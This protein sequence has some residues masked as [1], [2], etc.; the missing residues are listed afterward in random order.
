MLYCIVLIEEYELVIITK[1]PYADWTPAGPEMAKAQCY[2]MQ[3]PIG[4]LD[5][6]NAPREDPCVWGNYSILR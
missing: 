2:L 3:S 6:V 1:F 5:H 4:I